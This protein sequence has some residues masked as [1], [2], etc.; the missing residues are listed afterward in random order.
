MFKVGNYNKNVCYDS[1]PAISRKRL[2]GFLY[3]A[4]RALLWKK[5][6][7][8][9]WSILTEEAGGIF[10][11]P[12]WIYVFIEKWSQHLSGN[13]MCL[14]L[15]KLA[16]CYYVMQRKELDR[17]VFNKS[18]FLKGFANF[19]EFSFYRQKKVADYECHIFF[20]ERNS[21]SY[22]IFHSLCSRT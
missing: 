9:W 16:H 14:K 20:A 13:N 5:R 3:L 1:S 15:L 22:L 8:E 17:L 4:G 6:K 19:C 18:I 2:I 10:L 7:N 11:C 21:F 12:G